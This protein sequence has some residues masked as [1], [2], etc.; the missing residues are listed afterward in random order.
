MDIDDDAL[1]ELEREHAREIEAAA[2]AAAAGGGVDDDLDV[3]SSSAAMRMPDPATAMRMAQQLLN[4]IGKDDH[5]DF[6]G[7]SH[8]DDDKDVLDE[9][10]MLEGEVKGQQRTGRSSSDAAMDGDDDANEAGSGDGEMDED[11]MLAE[12]EAEAARLVEEE[13]RQLNAKNNSSSI[14]VPPP[15]SKRSREPTP[16]RQ[17]KPNAQVADGGTTV[18]ESTTTVVV[19]SRSFV[20][21]TAASTTTSS[22]SSSSSS[23][24]HLRSQLH[25]LKVEAVELKR[26]GQAQAALDTLRRY[27]A[28]QAQIESIERREDNANKDDN[29]AVN[30]QDANSST[31]PSSISSRPTRPSPASSSSAGNA[32]LAANS[33]IAT[34]ASQPSTLSTASTSPVSSSS[35][36]D[37]SGGSGGSDSGGGGGSGKLS[38]RQSLEYEDLIQK[39][40][41]QIESLNSAMKMI[42]A[43]G[44]TIANSGGNNVGSSSSPTSTASGAV[45]PGSKQAK[46]L[47]LQ[48]FRAKTRSIKDRD[49]VMLAREKGLKPPMSHIETITVQQELAFPHLHEDCIE[50][51]VLRAKDLQHSSATKHAKDLQPF[52]QVWLEYAVDLDGNTKNTS[53]HTS[54]AMKGASPCWEQPSSS[55]SASSPSPQSSSSSTQPSPSSSARWI[56]PLPYSRRTSQARESLRSSL[57]MLHRS[58]LI[59]SV[60]HKRSF[61]FSPVEIGR[62]EWRVKEFATRSEQR[63]TL[64]LRDPST[65]SRSGELE[66]MV[67]MRRPLEGIDLRE[68]P[69][70]LWVVDEFVEEGTT[71]ATTTTPQQTQHTH[72]AMNDQ[73]AAPQKPRATATA[74][75]PSSVT[76]SRSSSTTTVPSA[77][78]TAAPSTNAAAASSSSTLAS[79]SAVDLPPGL[80]LDNP[81][82]IVHMIS[83]DVLDAEVALIQAEL[84]AARSKG[85]AELIESLEER[86]T[87]A[88]IQLQVLVAGVQAGKITLDAYLDSLRQSIQSQTKLAQALLKSNRKLDA[89]RVM[90]RVKIMRDEVKNAEENQEELEEC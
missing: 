15:T 4:N 59:F 75:V 80:D 42:V 24:S 43:E 31:S 40:D 3:D 22:A 64:K 54:S 87:A 27:K 44:S 56:I 62:A 73:T 18:T 17:Q 68:V 26:S 46:L 60:Q 38:I 45:A 66:V 71:T 1:R 16:T 7:A 6:G 52:V 47:A 53:A 55:S 78:S 76:P 86:L 67:R 35:S 14:D 41:A 12:A 65:N 58:R 81:H 34:P 2:S 84:E 69:L 79:S 30:Q 77:P 21:A 23:L 10:V 83:N 33:S 13:E 28:I 50:V 88:Q 11:A 57:K 9:L 32:S 72:A 61:L 25:S 8:Q 39:L 63:S 36:P 5:D 20:A 74:P 37:G 51:S 89:L 49:L 82:E 85:D 48:Y 29:Q 19:E 90:R 70:Q